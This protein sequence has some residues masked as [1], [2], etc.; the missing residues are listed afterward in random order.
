MSDFQK[1]WSLEDWKRKLKEQ[2]EESAEYR[3]KLYERVGLASKKMVLDVGCGTGVITQD[4][5][6][7]CDGKV[8]GIDIDDEK[9]DLAKQLLAESSNVELMNAD[10]TDLPFP[11]EHFDLVHFNIVLMHIKDPQKALN[12]FARVTKPGGHVLAAL[13]PDHAAR[14]DYPENKMAQPIINAIAEL[15]GD[16]AA[17]R[18]LKYYFGNAGLDTE[19][20]MLTEPEFVLIMDDE[21]HRA[22][23]EQHWWTHEKIM[24]ADG[25]TDEEIETYHSETAESIEKGVRFS[26]TPCFYAIGRKI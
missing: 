18:K 21:K 16:P 25:W 22:K 9:L 3:H 19:M 5:A 10:A 23:F 1:E 14:I 6:G 2:A 20:G 15:G 8:T 13:E 17:G 26:L 24:R 7:L 12:E 4:I 11:D